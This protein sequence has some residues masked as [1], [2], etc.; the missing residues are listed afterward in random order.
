MQEKD[1][2]NRDLQKSSDDFGM[3]FFTNFFSNTMS[4]LNILLCN[5]ASQNISAAMTTQVMCGQWM[6][7][8][9]H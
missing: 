8:D 5:L 9:S 6:N 3:V 1:K 7:I 2:G 4:F